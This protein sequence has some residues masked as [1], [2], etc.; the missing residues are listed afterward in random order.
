[1]TATR[2]GILTGALI[3]TAT[4]FVLLLWV[5][6]HLKGKEFHTPALLEF[7]PGASQPEAEAP[8]GPATEAREPLVV[9]RWLRRTLND[10]GIPLV[11]ENGDP[12]GED[13]EGCILHG[14]LIW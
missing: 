6:F 2:Q 4:A 5:D 7:D 11:L 9:S 3:A 10:A 14:K 13:A 8:M 1:M 12:S